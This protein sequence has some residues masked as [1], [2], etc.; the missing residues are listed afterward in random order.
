MGGRR[1]Q[2]RHEFPE[3]CNMTLLFS[4][5]FTMWCAIAVNT[6]DTTHGFFAIERET[7]P[8]RKTRAAI[9]NIRDC[10]RWWDTTRSATENLA[11]RF[12]YNSVVE[13]VIVVTDAKCLG[14]SCTQSIWFCRK[15]LDNYGRRR[16]TIPKVV[17][18]VS[19]RSSPEYERTKGCGSTM[20]SAIDTDSKKDPASN[21]KTGSV[22]V[23][24]VRTLRDNGGRFRF[25]FAWG[26]EGQTPNKKCTLY[27][28]LVW[29]S[30]NFYIMR[31]WKL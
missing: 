11:W 12:S 29:T 9:D 28:S 30:S 16:S 31:D 23:A 25:I 14:S 21:W 26:G 7:L 18:Q 1:E 2:K 10:T 4:L 5:Y 20:D 6:D 13:A 17:S 19:R 24:P 27:F 22:V 8:S 15:K 3:W